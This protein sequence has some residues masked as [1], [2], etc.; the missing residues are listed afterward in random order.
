VSRSTSPSVSQT[1][2]SK[3][4]WSFRRIWT[5]A[6]AD[7]PVSVSTRPVVDEHAVSSLQPVSVLPSFR[8]L[9]S[10]GA[11]S[12]PL[13]NR[14]GA[15]QN[16]FLYHSIILLCTGML[17]VFAMFLQLPRWKLLTTLYTL[18]VLHG[19]ACF[20]FVCFKVPFVVR[21]FV[22]QVSTGY[23]T[24]GRTTRTCYTKQ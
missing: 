1:S 17:C 11:C 21:F 19:L 9:L 6:S 5:R 12:R 24:K 22:C 15:L 7:E 20:P 4:K 13:G 16:M 23:D 8:R 18:R 10:F 2:T 14:G 3:S